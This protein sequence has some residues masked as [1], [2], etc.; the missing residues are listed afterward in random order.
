MNNNR[1]RY[2]LT[3][4]I[5]FVFIS[6]IIF[7]Y[8]Y[9]NNRTFINSGNDGLIQ[10]YKALLYYSEYLKTIISNIFKGKFIIPHW[11]FN[12]GEGS[13]IL[14]TLHFYTIGDPLSVF[15][16]FF[17]RNN[18]YVYYDLSILIRLYLAG[19]I[20]SNLCFYTGKDNIYAVL[21][22]SFAYIFSY[23]GLL[24]VNEHIYFFPIKN[25]IIN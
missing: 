11:D 10:H 24:N 22:G 13:D 1:K 2:Y 14:K 20:F 25:N 8:Y 12:I 17:N 7:S 4:T 16:I 19:I 15:S 18:M 3:Y 9:L 6:L 23:W 5:L 21:A